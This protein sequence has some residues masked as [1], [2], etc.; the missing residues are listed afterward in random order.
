MGYFAFIAIFTYFVIS[1]VKR[2]ITKILF[3]L[4]AK[5]SKDNLEKICP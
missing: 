2:L 3:D 4:F 1:P 5:N